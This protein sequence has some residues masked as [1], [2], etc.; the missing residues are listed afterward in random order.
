MSGRRSG[1]A[2]GARGLGLA[3]AALASAAFFG[4]ACAPEAAESRAPALEVP[5][6]DALPASVE[7][8]LYGST[9]SCGRDTECPG[10][11]CFYGSCI[12]LLIA[13]QRWMQDAIT[14]RLVD[15]LDVNVALR[16]RVVARLV[17]VLDRQETDL[18]FRARALIPL[19]ALGEA[20]I[21]RRALAMGDE[22]LEAAAA[23]ALTRLGDPEGL[24]LAQ[25]LTEHTSP[26]LA[27]EAV[28][29]LGAS[30]LAQALPALLRNLAP[31]LDG[32][33]LRAVV[34]ALGELG[35]PRAVRP[36]V[37]F[38]QDGPDFLRHRIVTAL[39]RLTRAPVGSKPADWVAWVADHAPPEP[40]A[41]VL[42]DQQV[43][44]GLGIPSP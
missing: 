13:E 19:E 43:D 17:A 44:D 9:Q 18:A 1:T 4:P 27:V 20:S 7:S 35:D 36:L 2:R 16:P 34:D 37:T 26:V 8:M 22:R 30:E 6:G 29:A 14:S 3:I 5:P 33:L 42:R 40:P 24:P 10:R 25:A 15:T 12:G 28:R 11:V 23:L 38:L 41:Y 39:R 21:I 31:D 32:A